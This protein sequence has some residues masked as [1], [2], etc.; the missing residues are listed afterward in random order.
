VL[1]RPAIPASAPPADSTRFPPGVHRSQP[2]RGDGAEQ[3]LRDRKP[4]GGG[5][6]PRYEG[7]P[8]LWRLDTREP[9]PSV[10]R[11]IVRPIGPLRTRSGSPHPATPPRVTGC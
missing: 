5:N 1:A 8:C 3:E 6:G 9:A 2:A 4:H 7:T 11:R 10:H